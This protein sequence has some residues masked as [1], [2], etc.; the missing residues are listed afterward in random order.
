MSTVM[1]LRVACARWGWDDGIVGWIRLAARWSVKKMGVGGDGL[2]KYE[3][4]M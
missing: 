2:V 3:R 4:R 1:P